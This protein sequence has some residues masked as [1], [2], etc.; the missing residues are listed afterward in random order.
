MT[1]PMMV[2]TVVNIFLEG[3]ILTIWF[4]WPCKY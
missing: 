2:K 1:K 4:Y 3:K